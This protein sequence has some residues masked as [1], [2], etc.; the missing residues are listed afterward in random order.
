M[1]RWVNKWEAT[2]GEKR[3]DAGKNP[4]EFGIQRALLFCI[5]VAQPGTLF[6]L[7]MLLSGNVRLT[8]LRT[9]GSDGEERER[10]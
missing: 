10:R 8:S 1:D 9:T 4:C 3:E 7:L 2:E 6:L 5:I